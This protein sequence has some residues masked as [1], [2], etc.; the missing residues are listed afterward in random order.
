MLTCRLAL[1]ALIALSLATASA[2]LAETFPSRPITIISPLAAGSGVDLVARVYGDQLSKK[3]GKPVIIENKTGAATM[4]GTN[5]VAT[6]QPDGVFEIRTSEAFAAFVAALI[7]LPNTSGL[8]F[9]AAAESTTYVLPAPLLAKALASS[10]TPEPI[11]SP[12]T[13]WP[14]VSARLRAMATSS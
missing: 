8:K 4:I 7:A 11:T 6:S 5:Y 13:S 12:F 10:P 14:P 3:L 2:V 1:P 9:A